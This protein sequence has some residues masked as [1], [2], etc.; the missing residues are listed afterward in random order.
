MC[1]G[2]GQIAATELDAGEMVER[3]C[4]AGAVAC[5]PAER[6]RLMQMLERLLRGAERVVDP[7]KSS[8]CGALIV[9]VAHVFQ[10]RN[11]TVEVVQRIPGFAQGIVN[12]AYVVQRAGLGPFIVN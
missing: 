5:C 6:E 11:R 4:F 10:Y 12:Q 1:A 7:A 2:L 3:K 9:S 8:E